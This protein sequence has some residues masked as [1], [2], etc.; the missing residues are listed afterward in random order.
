[1]FIL[2][3]GA[4]KLFN[5]QD[6]VKLNQPTPNLKTTIKD[7]KQKIIKKHKK[8]SGQKD[9]TENKVNTPP[10]VIEDPSNNTDIAGND[11]ESNTE[12]ENKEE[13]NIKVVDES[14][15]IHQAAP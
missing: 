9:S 3:F 14:S 7:K 11:A 8:I 2:V 5:S 12:K 6:N 10:T 13:V 4:I 1:M 15:Q